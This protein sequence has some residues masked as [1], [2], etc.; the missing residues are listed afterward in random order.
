MIIRDAYTARRKNECTDKCNTIYNE[1]QKYKQLAEKLLA[2]INYLINEGFYKSTYNVDEMHR[3]IQYARGENAI[4]EI[5]KIREQA[6]RSAS[7]QYMP[8]VAATA[9]GRS[10]RAADGGRSGKRAAQ[11]GG[12]E[13]QAMDRLKMYN[14]QGLI[15][16]SFTKDPVARGAAIGTDETP[17]PFSAG[18]SAGIAYTSGINQDFI[19]Q[20]TPALG[21]AGGAR[22]RAAKRV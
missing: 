6:A 9:G 20:L 7:S 22:K 5:R 1:C 4:E 2:H 16:N 12:V 11:R 15:G 21:K 3:E 13:I 18:S 17:L 8:G 19:N 10:K 14:V